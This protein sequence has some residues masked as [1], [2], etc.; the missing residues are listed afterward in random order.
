MH[1]SDY[2]ASIL[3]IVRVSVTFRVSSV[4]CPFWTF[5]PGNYFPLDFDTLLAGGFGVATVLRVC[6]V[7]GACGLCF[8]LERWIRLDL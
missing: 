7:A 5:D 2:G 8:A 4:V 1:L 3:R 6:C